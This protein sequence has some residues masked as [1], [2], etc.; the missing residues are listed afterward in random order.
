[1]LGRLDIPTAFIPKNCRLKGR[2]G[3]CKR[4]GQS[5]TINVTR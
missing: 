4:S 3:S 2:S 5:V 1:M